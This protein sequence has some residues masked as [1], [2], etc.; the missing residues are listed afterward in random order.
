MSKTLSAQQAPEVTSNLY[1]YLSTGYATSFFTPTILSEMGY[2][3]I[4]AQVM[5]IPIFIVASV[6]CIATS[7]AADKLRHR[8][9]F[10]IL[11]ICI[12]TVGFA[13]LF[14]HASVAVG[15]KYFAVYLV[16]TGNYMCQPTTLTWVQNN[17]G[18]HYKR[19][20]SSAMVR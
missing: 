20:V 2:G 6:F 10:C 9:G 3:P 11:G 7:F 17:M 12:L 13:I 8:Y 5:A 4:R 14:N 18:G 19:S 1:P 15:V 16:I